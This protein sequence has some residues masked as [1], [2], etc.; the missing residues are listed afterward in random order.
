MNSYCLLHE[1]RVCIGDAQCLC[2]ILATGLLE[3]TVRLMWAGQWYTPTILAAA[4]AGHYYTQTYRGRALR[5]GQQRKYKRGT[6]RPLLSLNW[7][8]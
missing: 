8:S 5:V 2:I 3:L 4:W 1:N 7:Q 6:V